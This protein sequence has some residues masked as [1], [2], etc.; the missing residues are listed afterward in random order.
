MPHPSWMESL[1][2]TEKHQETMTTKP[3][4]AKLSTMLVFAA[5]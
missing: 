3:P 4:F 5:L 1:T 2:E